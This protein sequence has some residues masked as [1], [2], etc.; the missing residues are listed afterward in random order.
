MVSTEIHRIK[1]HKHVMVRCTGCGTEKLV[2]YN[3]LKAGKTQ[4]CQSCRQKCGA[5][6]WLLRRMDAAQQRCNNP[7]NKAYRNYGGRGIQFK[8]LTVAESAVWVAQN[9]G[10]HK[11][12]E[13]DRIN[14]DGHYE[15]GNL[16][17]TTR[18][19]NT[20]NR[21]RS[22]VLRFNMFRMNYPQVRYADATLSNLLSAGL[23]D[24]EIVSRWNRPSCKPKGVY[25]TCS[26][27]DLGIVSL[28]TEGSSPTVT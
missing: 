15:P 1:G 13:I 16:R 23:T 28:L 19:V 9:L 3:N 18:R 14:T 6:D 17:Y 21:R 5:P 2:S 24:V 20:A 8:F 22:H 10:L 26:N 11:E 27:A 12:L 4:G 25:G 7:S